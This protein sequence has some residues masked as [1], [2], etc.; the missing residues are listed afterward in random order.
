MLH[1]FQMTPPLPPPTIH[2]SISK[3]YVLLGSS[4]FLFFLREEFQPSRDQKRKNLGVAAGNNICTSEIC[5]QGG[6]E[7]SYEE[8]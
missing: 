1:A 2:T 7:E 6:L 4:F 8:V 3:T 5:I